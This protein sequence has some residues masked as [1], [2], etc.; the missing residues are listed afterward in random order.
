MK[1]YLSL[2]VAFMML[3]GCLGVAPGLAEGEKVEL[4]YMTWNTEDT[5]A[6]IIVE[7]F[8]ASQDRIHVNYLSEATGGEAF[9]SKVMSLLAAEEGL[10]ILGIYNNE[11]YMNYI[12][13]GYLEPLSAMM[14]AHNYDTEGM[15]DCVNQLKVNDECYALPHRKSVEALFYNTEIF[16]EAGIPYP[17]KLTWAEFMDLAKKLTFTR[18]DG[19]NCVGLG[20]NVRR[21]AFDEIQALPA[22]YGEAMTDD[23]L[24]HFKE[25]LERLY[26]WYITDKSTTDYAEIIA[27]GNGGQTT[28]FC[29]GEMAMFA[30]GDFAL[31]VLSDGADDPDFKW[32]VAYFPYDPETMEPGTSY[33]KVT[34]T[35]ITSF[36]KHKEEAF[37]FLSYLCGPEGAKVIASKGTVPAYT[38]ETV[39]EA[40]RNS[41]APGINVDV[42]TTSNPLDYIIHSTKAPELME[43][44]RAEIEMMLIG[45]QD[46]DTTYENWNKQR[47]EILGK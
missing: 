40:F 20:G 45:E 13:L 35:G 6:P 25:C 23:E 3:L 15:G 12:A 26:R 8:N 44:S 36:S 33:G 30:E 9:Q 32:N 10:D 41:M 47:K 42:F 17:D 4:T 18:P 21:W 5:Y 19:R 11:L 34:G 27:M 28:V 38:D 31:T 2:I 29:S 16:D 43:M 22:Q 39:T 14:T 1:K 37:E 7:A 46:V 24:P